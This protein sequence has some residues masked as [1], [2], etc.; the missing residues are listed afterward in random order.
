MA[1]PRVHHDISVLNGPLRFSLRACVP[2][3]LSHVEVGQRA[4]PVVLHEVPEES[5]GGQGVPHAVCSST[6]GA[7]SK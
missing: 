2:S 7:A 3:Q 5:P 6:P 4:E 1:L